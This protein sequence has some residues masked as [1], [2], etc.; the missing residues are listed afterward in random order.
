[1]AGAITARDSLGKKGG[2]QRR[3]SARPGA[4]HAGLQ[5][6]TPLSRAIKWMTWLNA[7]Q[8]KVMRSLEKSRKSAIRDPAE[9]RARRNRT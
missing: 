8:R 5:I 7:G 9:D 2:F 1:M 3:D 4:F 6:K